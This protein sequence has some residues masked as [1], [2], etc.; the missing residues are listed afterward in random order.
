MVAGA[1]SGKTT[2]LVKALTHLAQ[3]RRRELKM[4]G[5]RIACI[6]YTEVATKEISGDVGDDGLFH[7]STYIALCGRLYARSKSISRRG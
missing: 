7:V 1:G 3:T 4:R 5:Q 6:T 2:S